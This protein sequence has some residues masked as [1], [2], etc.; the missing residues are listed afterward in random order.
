MKIIVG[1]KT[2]YFSKKKYAV[3]M[4]NL[5]NERLFHVSVR[6]FFQIEHQHKNT[7]L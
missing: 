4:W 3:F 1:V 7:K 2:A 5:K 6:L